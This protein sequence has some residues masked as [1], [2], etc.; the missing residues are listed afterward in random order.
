MKKG[1]AD[2]DRTDAFVC[3]GKPNCSLEREFIK[4]SYANVTRSI[5]R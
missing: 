4:Q 2:T 3:L 1:A 5:G